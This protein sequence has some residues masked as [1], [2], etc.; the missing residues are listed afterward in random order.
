MVVYA[1]SKCDFQ[2]RHWAG[3]LHVFA[4]EIRNLAEPARNAANRMIERKSRCAEF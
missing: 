2:V 1:I 4:W 3:Q